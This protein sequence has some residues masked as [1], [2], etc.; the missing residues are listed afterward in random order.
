[1]ASPKRRKKIL[2]LCPSPRGTNPGQRLK[3][4]QYFDSWK[5]AGIDVTVSS[6]QT[7]RFWEVIYKPGHIPEKVFWTLVG[8][9]RR[10]LDLFRIPFYDGVY[11]FLWVTPFGSSLFEWLCRKLATK[12][13]YDIDDMVFMGDT[14]A[15]NRWISKLKG[16]KKMIYLMK[17]ADHVVV[18]TPK[19]DEFVGQYNP[20][21]TDISSTFN[22][23]RFC[24]V[25]EY[26]NKDVTIIGWTG[27]HSTI[28]YLH[29]LDDVF[30][31]VAKLR[32]IKLRV[33][34]NSTYECPGVEVENIAW[35]EAQEVQDLHHMDIGVYPV[36]KE[37]WV[38]GKSGCKAIT[39]MSIAIPAVATAFGT[40]FRVIDDGQ[41]GFLVDGHQQW[42]DTIV[43]L[44]DDSE[45]RKRVGLAGREK[46]IKEFSIQ[47]NKGKYLQIFNRLF[48]DR[49]Q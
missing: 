38:L 13:I 19:L 32:P 49:G 44:I 46:V 24:A 4:E 37:E 25:G 16:K 8:Y 31:D 41:N 9:L 11:I 17:V 48:K 10:I 15:A 45:L 43:K 39:Y 3:Y 2:V 36:P 26:K 40:N 29:L 42:V 12:L 6:F 34:S 14:S 22:T 1:M 47:A 35:T 23:D 33:I 28:K 20:H 30:R 5:E 7:D 27:S 18:C 21:R